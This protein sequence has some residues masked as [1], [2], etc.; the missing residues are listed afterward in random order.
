MKNSLIVS[1]IAAVY[2]DLEALKLIVKSLENQTYKNFEL[3]VAEDNDSHEIHDYIKSVTSIKIKHTLQEDNGIRKSRSINNAILSSSGEYLI[4]IDGD[5]IPYTT[6]IESHVKLSER[7]YIIS[8]RRL[9]LGNQ[10]SKRIRNGSLTSNFTEKFFFL[11]IPF[12]ILDRASHIEQGMRVSP[13]GWFYNNII[14]KRKR[15]TNLL[16]CN[17]SCFHKDMIEI[18]GFDESYEGTAVGDDTDLEWRFK[19][20]ELKIKSCKN[21][22]NVFHLY[23]TSEH[24]EVDSSEELKLMKERKI[25][26]IY[27]CENGLTSH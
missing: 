16:G 18:N 1:L 11:N 4:F 22:A 13:D 19:A 2:K 9:N 8:G 14:S 5:C 10:F 27:Y 26:N 25:N 23:H 20:N 21:I 7:G 6:F 17:F 12:M 15:N 3:V 24:R